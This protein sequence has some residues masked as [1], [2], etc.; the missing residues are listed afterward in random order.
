MTTT[1][2]RSL[3]LKRYWFQIESTNQIQC[4]WAVSFTEAKYKAAQRY[5]PQW[6]GISWIDISGGTSTGRDS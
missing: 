1:N 5:L 3:P 4:V 6:R 2:L